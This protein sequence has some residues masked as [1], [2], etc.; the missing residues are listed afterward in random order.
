MKFILNCCTKSHTLK[1][2]Q[3]FFLLSAHFI[4]TFTFTFYWLSSATSS[5]C[6]TAW[7]QSV[8]QRRCSVDRSVH[9][10]QFILGAWQRDSI[11]IWQLRCKTCSTF[12]TLWK[13]GTSLAPELM[14]SSLPD[15]KTKEKKKIDIISSREQTQ[16]PGSYS[17]NWPLNNTVVRVQLPHQDLHFLLQMVHPRIK[18]ESLP[19][20]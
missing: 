8:L 17:L 19:G 2:F 20:R 16:V 5:S 6:I 9:E 4:S 15:Y 14:Q 3:C 18:E 12:V 11:C 7:L 1:T 10:W 13:V